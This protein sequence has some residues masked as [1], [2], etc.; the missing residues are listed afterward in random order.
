MNVVCISETAGASIY[1]TINGSKPEPFQTV[2]P[3]HTFKYK[4]PFNVPEGKRQIKAI[5]VA[6]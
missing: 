3:K 2:G 6:E 4:E 1:F 5:A